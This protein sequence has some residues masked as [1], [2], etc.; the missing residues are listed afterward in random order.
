MLIV[1]K[2]SKFMTAVC[3]RSGGDYAYILEAFGPVPAFLY[4][5]SALLVIMPTG[6]PSC[7]LVS[8]HVY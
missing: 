6:E 1:D 8:H 3:F 5:W 2:K 7:Q 4:L